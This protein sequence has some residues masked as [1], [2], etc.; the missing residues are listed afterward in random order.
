MFVVRVGFAAIMMFPLGGGFSAG[1]QMVM[2]GALWGVGMAKT[3]YANAIQAVGPDA[4]VIAQPMIP[5]TSNVIQ[6]LVDS[7][8]C[9]DLVN[10]AGG[11]QSAGGQP[12]VPTPQPITVSNGAGGGYVTWRY[13]LSTG[14]ETS[15][16]VCGTV[17]V[18]EAGQN[19]S[20]IAGVNVDMSAVQQGVLTNIISGSIRQ[21]V[22]NVATQLWITKTAAALTPFQGIL[23]SAVNQYTQE[24][25]TAATSEQAAINA[26]IQGSASQ[27]RNGNLDL[28]TSEVRQS[29]LGWTAAGAYYLE[30]AKLNAATLLSTPLEFSPEPPK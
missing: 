29:T 20:T 19:E 3:L 18:Q 30:I 8:L 23:T 15:D 21:P 13:A 14:N 25:T 24:L 2:Q 10:L 27:A 17:T 28:L 9:M 4:I 1:Q 7:E 5:G 6:G 11:I 16:P 26:A 12:L 22:Q